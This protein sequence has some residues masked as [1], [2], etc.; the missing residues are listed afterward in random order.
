[1]RPA[2][3]CAPLG[4]TSTALAIARQL[5]GPELMKTRVM[6]LNASDERGINVVRQKVRGAYTHKCM[7][8]SGMLGWLRVRAP[9]GGLCMQMLRGGRQKWFDQ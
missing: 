1:M 5:Y 9:E 3:A 2:T 7:K 6:E 8:R 4:K